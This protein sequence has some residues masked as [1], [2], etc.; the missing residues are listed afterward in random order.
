MLA[1]MI[2]VFREVL[3]AGLIVGVVLAASRG[4]P[5]RRRSVALGLL[6]GVAGS[7]VVAIFTASISEA[8]DGRGQELF[9]AGILMLAVL[10]L[11]WHVVWMAEHAREMTARLRHLG[12]EVAAGQQP[13]MALGIAVAVAVMREGSELVLFMTGLVMQG[14]DS[15]WSLLGGSLLGLGL[16][17]AMSGALYFGLSFIPLKRV[18]TVTGLLVTL[19]AAG[20]AAEAVR[21]LS[22]AGVLNVL[23]TPLWNTS[24]I[25]PES[26]WIGRILHILVGYNERPTGM[27]L[28]AYTVTAA[29]I[30]GL[31]YYPRRRHATVQHHA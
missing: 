4:I 29:T 1:A 7:I 12:T 10:M 21:Q 3:E 14:Q 16:G 31:T 13:L 2:L 25:L 17:A 9:A 8:F 28:I 27:Q 26:G 11:S 24:W 20:L 5:E 19:L 6:A 22:N 18:F 23:D 15:M 30:L